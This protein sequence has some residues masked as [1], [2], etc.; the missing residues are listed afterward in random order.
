MEGAV[1]LPVY[2]MERRA[3]IWAKGLSYRYIRLVAKIGSITRNY[4]AK[5]PWRE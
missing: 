2:L 1:D 4:D 3:F 5:N